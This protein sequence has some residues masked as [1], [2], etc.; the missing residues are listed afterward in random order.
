MTEL[1]FATAMSR[2]YGRTVRMAFTLPPGRRE[3]LLRQVARVYR[4]EWARLSKG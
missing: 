3:Q 1:E 2:R 4:A